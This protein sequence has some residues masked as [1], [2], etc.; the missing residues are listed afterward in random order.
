MSTDVQGG[1]P[2][3]RFR[4]L[5]FPVHIDLTFVLFV[6]FLGFSPGL[7][8]QRAPRLGAA[9]VLPCCFTNSVTPSRPPDRGEPGDRA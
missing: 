9:R 7:P 5:G 1:R 4:V 2:L 3:A 8:S 6:G